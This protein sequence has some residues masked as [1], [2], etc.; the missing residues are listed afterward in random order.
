MK[1]RLISERVGF[2]Y[3]VLDSIRCWYVNDQYHRDDHGPATEDVYYGYCAW[4]EHGKFMSYNN[5]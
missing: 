5:R 4:W 1:R 2:R 3:D